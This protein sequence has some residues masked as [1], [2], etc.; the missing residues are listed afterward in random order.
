MGMGQQQ[1]A[2]PD[3]VAHEFLAEAADPCARIKNDALVARE[4]L[5]AAGIAAVHHMFR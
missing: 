2:A 4:H 3:L 1:G 5:K